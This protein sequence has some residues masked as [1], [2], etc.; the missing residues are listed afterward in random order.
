MS[1]TLRPSEPLDVDAL[2][3]AL[4]RRIADVPHA[5]PRRRRASGADRGR[6]R[7]SH[8]DL[9]QAVD[10]AAAL[11]ADL[12]ARRRPRDDRRR[13]LRRADRAAVRGRPPRRVGARSNARL[14]ASELD[15]IA[16]HARPK[17]IA[18]TTDASPTR[19][20]MPNG[21]VRHPPHAA[22]RHRRMVV[23]RRRERAGRTG[24]R[25]RCRA[26]RGADLHDRH[27]RHAEGRDAV[28]SQPAVHRGDVEHAAPRVAR[29][30]RHTV[31][32][33]SHVW[34]RRSAS[35]ACTRARRCGSR[36]FAGSRARRARR[37]RRHNLPGRAR[38][39]REAARTPAHARPRMARATP[40]L[41]VFGRLTARREPEGARRAPV[42]VPLHNGYG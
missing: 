41:R 40:A 31:L 7:L 5:G 30:R 10:A 39:A 23:P 2:L 16:A 29:R 8:G 26:M 36:A 25:R 6:A 35:A 37:R 4:P 12:R 27:D 32:P 42:G 21:T 17:L 33:V 18:F 19:A 22:G 38:D 14:S 9:S 15:A 34:P 13:K 3:A 20:R 1:S 28:A 11:L 24:R